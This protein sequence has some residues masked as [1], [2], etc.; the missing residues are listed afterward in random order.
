[1]EA[2]KYIVLVEFHFVLRRLYL[3][4]LQDCFEVQWGAFR[5]YSQVLLSLVI[6]F[7]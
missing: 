1:M 4:H 3:K 5:L 7:F 2:Q 6:L